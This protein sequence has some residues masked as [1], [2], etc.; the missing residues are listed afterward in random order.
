MFEEYLEGIHAEQ[1]RGLDDE[2]PDDFGQW[3]GQLDI[4]E[5]IEFG[6]KAISHYL[7]KGLGSIKSEKKAKSSREN[8]KRGG[9]PKTVATIRHE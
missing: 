6:D 3:M 2:M 9:R 5:L 8:G 4:A 1:Y 7:A